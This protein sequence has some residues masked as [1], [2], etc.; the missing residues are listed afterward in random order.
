MLLVVFMRRGPEDF[1]FFLEDI[2]SD[3]YLMSLGPFPNGCGQSLS[4]GNDRET[5]VHMYSHS[6]ILIQ[7]ASCISH[8]SLVVAIILGLC[9][10]LHTD[11][12]VALQK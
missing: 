8:L 3:V 11:L 1:P 4:E 10:V 12:P 5:A 7:A 2:I 9:F 6:F